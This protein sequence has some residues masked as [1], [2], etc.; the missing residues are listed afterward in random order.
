[1][2]LTTHD[3]N[4]LRPDLF[5]RDQIWFTEKGSDG[6]SEL[7]SLAE[8]KGVRE[9]AAWEKQY[10][11]GRYGAVPLLNRFGEGLRRDGQE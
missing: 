6:S 1:L 4:L 2:I 11:A 5:R 9:D 8:V 7:Y 3:T 10:L